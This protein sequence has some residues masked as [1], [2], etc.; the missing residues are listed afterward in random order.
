M[1]N[2]INVLLIRM[3]RAKIQFVLAICCSVGVFSAAGHTQITTTNDCNGDGK[4]DIIKD[5]ENMLAFFDVNGNG[6]RDV[7]EPEFKNVDE[8]IVKCDKGTVSIVIIEKSGIVEEI[9][10]SFTED[11]DEDEDKTF[12]D[13]A[14]FRSL[15]WSEDRPLKWEDFEGEVPDPLPESGE[16][17]F[18]RTNI[19]SGIT[20]FFPNPE[21]DNTV[22]VTGIA[23]KALF[24]PSE[25]WANDDDKTD[26]LLNHEQ[27]HFDIAKIFALK[28]EKEMKKLVGKTFKSDAEVNNKVTKICDKNDKHHEA[29]EEKYDNKT[30]HGTDE[31]EQEKWDKKIKD[32]L[33]K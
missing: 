3:S 12:R 25:S 23:V 22:K 28:K 30:E 29:F 24:K 4:P 2:I 16:V 6:E 14:T 27:G 17:A 1:I 33:A 7:G 13:V 31:D 5:I 26:E 9:T 20:F 32:M 21:P 18:T 19:T 10:A 11:E 8:I 15:E